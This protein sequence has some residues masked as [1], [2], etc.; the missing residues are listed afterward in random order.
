[1][2]G[3]DIVAR[4]MSVATSGSPGRKPFQ[5]GNTWQYHPRSDRHSKIACWALMY[6]L[7]LESELLRHHV[8][9]GKVAIGIN[10]EMR[11]FAATAPRT[12]TSSSVEQLATP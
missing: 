7:L 9:T 3:L 5:N 6:D 8:A 4:S 1:M 12:S 10:H 11:D 2:N